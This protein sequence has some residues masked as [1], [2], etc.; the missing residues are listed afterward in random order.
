LEEM[1][2][3]ALFYFRND[4]DYEAKGDRKFLTP[5]ILETMIDIRKRLE[6]CH[7]FS[8]EG[9]E[10]VFQAFLVERRIKL[11]Q[12]AQ[13]IRVAL[14]GRTASP[15]LFEVMEVLGKDDVLARIEKAVTHIGAKK[16]P[17]EMPS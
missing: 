16:N 12:I 10:A 1:A 5:D 13:P 15:G 14:T 11:A 9:L 6:A 7:N 17:P 2:E 3:G 4:Y 8:Q